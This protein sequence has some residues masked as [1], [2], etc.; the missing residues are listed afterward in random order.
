MKQTLNY[1]FKRIALLPYCLI[2]L[3]FGLLLAGCG[4]KPSNAN[5]PIKEKT[6]SI[7]VRTIKAEQRTFERRVT[8]QGNLE[9]KQFA[10]V[11]ARVA[12]NLDSIFVDEGDRVEA[13]KTVLFQIDPLSLQ[14]ALT[15][16]EQQLAVTEASLAVAQA[17]L[18]KAEAEASKVAR[19]FE[20]FE[21]LHTDGRVTDN[22]FELRQLQ[23]EQAKA[24]LAVSKAQ[25]GLAASQVEQAVAALEIS[26]KNLQDSKSV[27]PISGVVTM[28]HKE[29]GE[30]VALGEIVMRIE[31]PSSIEAVAYL[32]AAYYAEV[33]P[34][35]TQARLMI[36]GKAA[37]SF[38]VTYRS[39]VINTTLRTFEIKGK[40]EAT[41]AVAGAMADITLVFESRKAI[42]IPSNALLQ[43]NGKPS[44]FISREGKS[45]LKNLETSLI[46]EGWTEVSSG[47]EA[48]DLVIT[49]GQTQLREGMA[50]TIL[51]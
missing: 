37:G 23:H 33:T 31:D 47:L 28:R 25:V 11:A 32:P 21:R 6:Q 10:N 49:E 39:P 51:K 40:A 15:A 8:V 29:P 2:A 5:E 38:T 46:N 24:G 43:R 12:G 17:S 35:K 19:D 3:L 1:N 45:V 9:A 27:A 42:G 20:R 4:K 13:N 22:E 41:E 14:N 30:H 16:A 26:R 7:A 36:A 18:G 50:V 44:V 48:D 34:G